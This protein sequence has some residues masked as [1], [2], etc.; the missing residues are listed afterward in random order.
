MAKK[1]VTRV[2]TMHLQAGEAGPAT[3]GKDLGPLGINLMQFCKQY[4]ELTSG[5]RGHV[6][7]A[8]VTVYEDRAF[9]ITVKQPTTASLIRQVTGLSGGSPRPGHHSGGVVTT[10]QLRQVAEAKLPD[11]NTDDLDQA[12]KIVAGTARSMG[13]QIKD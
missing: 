10:A 9:D 5:R 11:L 8:V 12:V 6:V 3:V 13:L 1:K 4:N 7:P 2:V